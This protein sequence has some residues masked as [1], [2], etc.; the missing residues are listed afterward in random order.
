MDNIT[1]RKTKEKYQESVEEVPEEIVDLRIDKTKDYIF[2]ENEV[3]FFPDDDIDQRDVFFNFTT[4][5]NLNTTLHDEQSKMFL[6]SVV[7]IDDVEIPEETTYEKNDLGYY[8][9]K[10]REYSD[11]KFNK[12]VSLIVNDYD[13][14]I[15]NG[16]KIASIKSYIVDITTGKLVDSATL[17]QEFNL[18]E[19]KIIE[20]VQKRLSDTQVLDEDTQV[21]D[22]EGTIE[23][24]KNATYDGGLK[25]LSISKNGNLAINFIVKSNKI[26]Y[27]DSIEIN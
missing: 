19:E 4:L 18:T 7:K 9:F 27:N 1:K 25:A 15:I 3:E 6:N 10:Y 24:L 21:I 13:Y 17:L 12:Y 14:D 20:Q 2:Y 8:S 26:N 16:S 5:A 22:I 11:N 23:S